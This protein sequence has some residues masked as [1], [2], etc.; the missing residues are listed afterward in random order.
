MEI[1]LDIST[2][3][4]KLSSLIDDDDKDK[5][6]SKSNERITIDIDLNSISF[7]SPIDF[8]IQPNNYVREQVYIDPNWTVKE[9]IENVPPPIGWE[10]MFS[11]A[12]ADLCLISSNLARLGE[13][14][15]RNKN[16]FRALEL[17][18]LNK[19]KVILFGQDPYHQKNRNTS[20][21][22][23]QGLS[24]SISRDDTLEK[25]SVYNMFKE[26]EDCYPE[27]FRMPNH[28]DLTKWAEQGVLL[29]NT[30]LT[31][32]P[33]AAGSHMKPRNLWHSFISKI[34]TTIVLRDAQKHNNK[35]IKPIFV[36]LGGEAQRTIPRFLNENIEKVDI[37]TAAH[38][39]PLSAHLFFGSKVFK[40]INNKLSSYGQTEI[41]WNVD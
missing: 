41:D 35:L 24:F 7:D 33:G 37:I 12:Y 36:L 22:R 3:S 23:A 1:S 13:Y 40:K 14:Y 39:S 21:P 31:V 9:I 8:T 28:G 5:N 25:H 34:V 11:E 17:T 4:H 19:V 10:Q 38:P 29:L 30:C 20:E 15:P 18:P 2:T 32:S 6:N 16:L 27:T 26:I